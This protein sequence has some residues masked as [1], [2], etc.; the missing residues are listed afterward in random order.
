VFRLQET[1]GT[2]ATFLLFAIIG[3]FALLFIALKVPE[4]KGLSLEEIEA[5]LSS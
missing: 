3:L 1:I 5:K 4:T 2:A